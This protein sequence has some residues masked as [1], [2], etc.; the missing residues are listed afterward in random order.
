MPLSANIGKIQM[1][2][3]ILISV[4]RPG[5]VGVNNFAL[6]QA[7]LNIILNA[8]ELTMLAIGSLVILTVIYKKN[9]IKTI[10][11]N[12]RLTSKPDHLDMRDKFA[13]FCGS[14][15]IVPMFLSTMFP[16]WDFSWLVN[17]P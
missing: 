8:A 9:Q 17:N 4:L 5:E 2:E 13:I 3:I 14:C 11:Q 16:P 1:K 10:T 7:L 15:L 6:L 12:F